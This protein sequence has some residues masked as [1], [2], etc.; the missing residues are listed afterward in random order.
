MKTI[1]PPDP[2]F[3]YNQWIQWI[4]QQVTKSRYDKK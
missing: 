3:D 2:I 4:H 1:L